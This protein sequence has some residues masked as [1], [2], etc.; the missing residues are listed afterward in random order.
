MIRMARPR[1]EDEVIGADADHVGKRVLFVCI[2]NACRSQMAETFARAYGSDVLA[3]ASAGWSPA[4]AVPAETLRAMQE[5]HLDMTGQVPKSLLEMVG[6]KFDLI[7]NMSGRPL[8]PIG[9]AEVRVWQVP[10]PIGM[11]YKGHCTVRDQIERLVMYLIEDC[12]RI[13]K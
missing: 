8:R 12:R 5:K 7:V 9:G 1:G 4:Q 3:P 11:D 2:G 10:D 13:A 6:A